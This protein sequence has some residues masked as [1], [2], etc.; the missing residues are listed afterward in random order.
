MDCHNRPS[1]D[2]RSPA[3][4]V[5][6][7]MAAGEIPPELPEVKK[8]AMDVL[9]AGYDDR[10]TAM[11]TIEEQVMEHYREN[12]PDI[13]NGEATLIAQAI[14]GLQN[15]YSLNQFPYMKVR[16][17]VYPNHIGHLE[18]AGCA[19]CHDD[20]HLAESGTTISRDCNLCHT[21]TAQGIARNM[22]VGTINDSLAFRH[23]V[24]IGEAWKD[25]LCVECH[26][27]LY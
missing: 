17:D 10:D 23:P 5:D 1:H 24:D 4:Y 9:H 19:R 20:L 27:A 22:Q 12:F 21:I 25:Y 14:K 18:S 3:N 6:R 16:W 13:S 2:Y 15:G 7:L 26:L 8:V 11:M